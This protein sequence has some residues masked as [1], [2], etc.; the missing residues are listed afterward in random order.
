M[1]ER[2]GLIYILKKREFICLFRV[3]V[4]LFFLFLKI[5]DSMLDCFF[6]YNIIVLKRNSECFYVM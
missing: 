2:I 3:L 1:N 4:V 6:W 5:I